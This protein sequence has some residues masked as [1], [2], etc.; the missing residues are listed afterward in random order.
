M[1]GGRTCRRPAPIDKPGDP[2]VSQTV[3]P[4]SIAAVPAA[5]ASG[6]FVTHSAWLAV[7]HTC[8]YIWGDCRKWKQHDTLLSNILRTSDQMSLVTAA[9]VCKQKAAMIYQPIWCCLQDK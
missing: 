1:Q 9:V 7:H 2:P 6:I 3:E 8:T 4:I 5:Q